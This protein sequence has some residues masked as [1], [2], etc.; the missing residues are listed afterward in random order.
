MTIS[1]NA[2]PMITRAAA[3]RVG[4]IAGW[5]RYPLVVA[6]ALRAQGCQVYGLG[7]K[8]H[9]DPILARYCVEYQEMGI[10]RMGAAIRFFRRHGVTRATMAGKVHK[11][12]MFQ[13]MAF[14][15]HFPDWRTCR[16]FYRSFVTMSRDRKDDTLLGLVVQAFAEDGIEFAPATDFAPEL[17]VE[18]SLLSGRPLTKKQR[19][20][21][22]FGWKLA[23]EMGRLD[24]GQS[25]LV[26]DQAVLAVEAIEG[27]DECIRR[28]G[29]L[30]PTGGFTLIKVAKPQQDMRFDV[31]AIGIGTLE[32]LKEAGGRVL[33][34]EAG[35]TIVIDR[36]E[37]AAFAQRHNITVVA[38][39]SGDMDRASEAA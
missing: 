10:A 15:K 3:P 33:A 28:A 19:R 35:K 38:A 22:E 1:M 7:I 9:V 32:T 23:K 14:W 16:V 36:A 5:G 8:D 18:P 2:I 39:L 30:C 13:P 20:D 34:I 26:T 11:S 31:P 6:E 17:L 25:V 24:I 27:T 12:R 29:Q 37:V 4:L 21:V